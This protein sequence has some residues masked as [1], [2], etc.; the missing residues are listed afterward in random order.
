MFIYWSRGTERNLVAELSPMLCS[1]CSRLTPHG[2]VT[3]NKKLRLYGI[4]VAKWGKVHEK[5]CGICGFAAPASA[6]ETELYV[7]VHLRNEPIP[8]GQLA[9]M[10]ETVDGRDR[11]SAAWKSSH[12][13][14]AADPSRFINGNLVENEDQLMMMAGFITAGLSARELNVHPYEAYRQFLFTEGGVP[15]RV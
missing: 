2:L 15:S 4:P 13:T 11:M 12:E 14:F 7:A 3:E 8:A 5:M 10:A 9:S 6:E 1:Q